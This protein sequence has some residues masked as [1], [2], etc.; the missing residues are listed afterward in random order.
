MIK[1]T[2]IMLT[3]NYVHTKYPGIYEN[4]NWGGIIKEKNEIY[5]TPEIH[6]NRNKL[7]E[8]F[9]IVKNVDEYDGEGENER[10]NCVTDELDNSEVKYLMDH[11]ECYITRDRNYVIIT[12][13]YIQSIIG[14]RKRLEKAGWKKLYP[15]YATTAETYFKLV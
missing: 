4:T 13:P 14:H 3:F 2:Y 11:T 8:N 5:S 10:P 9:H 15:L 6:E 7:I 1:Y 12:S